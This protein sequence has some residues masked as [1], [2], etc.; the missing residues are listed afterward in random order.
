MRIPE[1]LS[2]WTHKHN[3]RRVGAL[4]VLSGCLL[5]APATWA[6]ANTT[7]VTQQANTFLAKLKA[8]MQGGSLFDRTHDVAVSDP[9]VQSAAPAESSVLPQFAFGGGWYSALY[10]TNLTGAAV[11]F[12]VSFVGDAGTPLTVPSLGGS[13]TQVKLAAY[14]TA[15][16][17][18]PNVG[19][20]VQ[21][22]AAFTLPN[23]VFGY[24]VFRG[25]GDQ[26]AVVPLSDAGASSNT[27]TWDETNLVTAVAIV[28]PSSTAATV[29]V[30]LWDENGNT[31]GTSS[32]ALPPNGKTAAALR[33][34]PG[35]G[36]MVGKRGSARFSVSSGSV[37]V[38]GLRFDGLAFTS[39]PTT[40]STSAS[41]SRSSILP[42]F[43][44]GGGWYTALYFTNLTGAAVSFP[45]SFVADAG[46]PLT[47]PSL[48]GSTTEVRLA[49]YGTAII[50]APNVGS[51]TQGY[52]A[53][54]LPSGVFG[55]GVFRQS[56]P[57]QSDQEAV[58]PLSFAGASSKTLTW[59]ETNLVTAVAI[60]NPSST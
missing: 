38:L 13:T 58:V 23:G 54:T 8:R 19:G 57:G 55:Y 44:F 12:P 41:S 30:T 59:D 52:A 9:T 5:L 43:A 6:Q 1:R 37:A 34:L 21:G 53:L 47:V 51:L 60:V 49:A 4:T 17:E 28:N 48:G 7:D 36:G 18:A 22:Y 40:T 14:G 11:S 16:I 3:K 27:L 10:F 35:L 15:I 24:G 25:Q 33:S 29:G 39:I 32:V 46:T 56:V 26:E 20:L 45:V 42:Q 31:I 50:E 2:M